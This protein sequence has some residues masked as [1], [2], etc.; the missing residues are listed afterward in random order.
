MHRLCP[1]R[2]AAIPLLRNEVL[3]RP[4]GEQSVGGKCCVSCRLWMPHFPLRN[5]AS[6]KGRFIV[7][8]Y[9]RR[10]LRHVCGERV[11]VADEGC[12]G[13]RLEPPP[14]HRGVPARGRAGGRRS[15]RFAR[16]GRISSGRR[17]RCPPPIVCRRTPQRQRTLWRQ[18]RPSRQR[19]RTRSALSAAPAPL[20]N[21]G[22]F[23]PPPT[24]TRWSARRSFAITR[25]PPRSRA[26]LK[27]ANS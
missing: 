7:R 20:R 3:R 21:G 24:S 4:R 25:L 13:G 6:T 15:R 16:S 17:A 8:E 5:D 26:S 23:L 22:P 12:R 14:L 27:P 11:A 1:G 18:G 9:A 10:V 2:L 19:A